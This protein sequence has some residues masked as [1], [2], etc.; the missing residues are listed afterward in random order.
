MKCLSFECFNSYSA[1]GCYLLDHQAVKSNN[2][3]GIG[4]KNEM[5][6]PKNLYEKCRAK[7]S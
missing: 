1:V 4:N 7:K 6:S 5:T 2:F 3:T